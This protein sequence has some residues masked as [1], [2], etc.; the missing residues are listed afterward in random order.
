VMNLIM[1]CVIFFHPV[2]SRK[3]PLLRGSN[4][5]SKQEHEMKSMVIG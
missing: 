4:G 5:K 1:V 3:F 2:V